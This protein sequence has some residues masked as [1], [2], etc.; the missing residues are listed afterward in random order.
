MQYNRSTESARLTTSSRAVRRL[1]AGSCATALAL[2]A[3]TALAATYQVGPTRTYKDLGS[4]AGRLNPGD[5]VEVDGNATYP[6]N[7]TFSRSGTASS[8]IIIRGKPVNGKRPVISGGTNT[9]QASGDH[10]VFEQ[11]DIT[12]GS[13]RCFFH[14]A[15]NITLRNSII[16][17]CPQHGILGA[18]DDSGSLFME[19]CEVHSCGEGTQKH[20]IY[21]A[22]DQ[23]THPGSV[24]RMDH[25][26]VHDARGGN[27]VK[28]RAERNEIRYNWIEGGTYRELE[29]IGPATSSSIRE[30]SEVVGNVL[31]KRNNFYVIRLGGDG[32]GDTGGRYRF[33]NN[34]ILTRSGGSSVFQLFDRVESLEAHNN[35]FAS[36]NGGTVSIL[37]DG[38]ARW[39]S[40]RLIAGTNNWLPSGSSNVPSEFKNSRTGS[41]PGF[42]SLSGLDFRLASNSPLINAGS[43]NPAGVSGHAFPSPT[44][45]PLFVPAAQQAPASDA[46]LSRPVVG[47]IDIGAFEYGTATGGSGG[48]GG[49][50][51]DDDDE[52]G[53]GGSAGSGQAGSGHGGSAGS[54]GTAGS[55]QGGSAGSD[56]DADPGQAGAAGSGDDDE[57][58]GQAGAGGSGDDDEDP[59]QAGSAGSGN[60]DDDP[61]QAG[62]AGS[63][64]DDEDDGQA[65]SGGFEGRTPELSCSTSRSD[66]A[67]F[68]ELALIGLAA[69]LGLRRKRD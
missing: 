28:S 52:P 8:P 9:I 63:N 40:G 38:D 42:V 17:D 60:D 7:V 19:H 33:V 22:T 36:Q 26:Y 61:G 67:P 18:D 15:H 68:G 43:D 49:G 14:H 27:N 23:S 65:G 30:D 34:T 2:A 12:G 35:V 55:G 48:S 56:D 20:Q 47:S 1:V 16:H 21:M 5:V 24:F 31:L 37:S 64:S 45:R 44:P 29:L 62:S 41:S 32:T 10:Y 59:G 66:K 4:V 51:G 54:A 3:S 11:L 39:V 58:P 25:C 6:G 69:A 53:Q 57:D 46:G 50:G 13:S